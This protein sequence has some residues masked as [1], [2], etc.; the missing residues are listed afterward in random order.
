MQLD[1][2]SSRVIFCP[3]G[4]LPLYYQLAPV[5]NYHQLAPIVDIQHSC[6]TKWTSLH[7]T[8]ND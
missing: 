3:A 8:C 6:N 4:W 2:D 5:F 7:S 1:I